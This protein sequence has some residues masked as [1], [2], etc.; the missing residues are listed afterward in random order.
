MESEFSLAF[1]DQYPVSEGH[2][3]IVPKRHVADYFELSSDEKKDIWALLD[4]VKD[5]LEKKFSPDGF[6]V[7]INV[8]EPAGQTI[9]HCHI[10]IIPRYKGDM[11]FPEGGVRGVI[12]GKQKYR[13]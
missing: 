11:E 3:L 7:G 6:N 1:Y 4:V 2:V 10:H 9:F 12:P 13:K 8:G 5:I